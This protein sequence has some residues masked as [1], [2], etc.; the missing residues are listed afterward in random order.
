M[1]RMMSEQNVNSERIGRFNR[2]FMPI[3]WILG[4][5]KLLIS[6]IACSCDFFDAQIN[7]FEREHFTANKNSRKQ[8]REGNEN[9]L[10][11]YFLWL[12]FMSHIFIF[13][14]FIFLDFVKVVAAKKKCQRGEIHRIVWPELVCG[15]KGA[16]VA[17]L[18]IKLI[19]CVFLCR[20]LHFIL[21]I[22]FW[23]KTF[24]IS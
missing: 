8:K 5:L 1:S 15:K 10:L 22:F 21:R 12:S 20:R 18:N 6:R 11:I 19:K 9:K 3:H 14:S 24:E 23:R 7:S 17:W 4:W 16:I 2:N 13:I